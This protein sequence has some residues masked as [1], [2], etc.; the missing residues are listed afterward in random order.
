[1]KIK[2]N[3]SVDSREVSRMEKSRENMCM[4]T[5]ISNDIMS[6][7]SLLQMFT[8]FQ[9]FYSQQDI[10]LYPWRYITW[11]RVTYIPLW[12]QYHWSDCGENV[13]FHLFIN[14]NIKQSNVYILLRVE[15]KKSVTMVLTSIYQKFLTK[16]LLPVLF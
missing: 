6:I 10:Y 4:N 1:M 7:T 3:Q 14:W 15:Y 2:K 12:S 13:S 8:S 9:D 16:T 5:K 11:Q